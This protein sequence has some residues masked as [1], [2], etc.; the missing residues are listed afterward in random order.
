MQEPRSKFRAKELAIVL[1]YYDLGVIH[2]IHSFRRG[3]TQAPKSLIV[4]EKGKFLLKKRAPGGDDPYRVAMGHDIQLYLLGEG[5]CA[6]QLVGTLQSNSTML[7][8]HG[9]IYELFEYIEGE[10]FDQGAA[11]TQ[12]A[13]RML[14]RYHEL[15]RKHECTYRVPR[16]S[17]HDNRAVRNSIQDVTPQISKN[18]SAFGREAELQTL[19]VELLEAYQVANEQVQASGILTEPEL[20]CHGDWHPG[21]MLFKDGKVIAVLDFDSLHMFH[22]LSDV[23]TGCMQFSL[24]SRG[25]NPSHWPDEPDVERAQRFMRGYGHTEE[26]SVERI[27]AVTAL[28]IESLVAEA[29]TPI[30][31]T[32]MFA[33]IHGFNFLRMIIRKIRWLQKHGTEMLAGSDRFAV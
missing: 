30:A 9:A 16:R 2:E 23:A 25:A 4:S 17:Y 26:W 32:G 19:A 33:G 13:G 24:I 7:Q 28:M 22:P 20:I 15:I 21:N 14:R 5:Y 11:T 10:G 1:S 27:Q 12:D 3:N 29:I 8:A 31:T 6:P 18:D